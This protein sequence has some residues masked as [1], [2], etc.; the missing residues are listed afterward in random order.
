MRHLLSIAVVEALNSHLF[1]LINL[2][3]GKESS[4]VRAKSKANEMSSGS[5]MMEDFLECIFT[6]R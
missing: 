2:R 3:T 4:G 5:G 6:R 1:K